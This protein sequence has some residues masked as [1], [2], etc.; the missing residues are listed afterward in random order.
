M[1]LRKTIVILLNII[2]VVIKDRNYMTQKL[3]KCI[4]HI[5]N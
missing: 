1:L 5:V 2:V 4:K 3:R